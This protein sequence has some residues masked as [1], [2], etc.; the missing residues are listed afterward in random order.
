MLKDTN[1]FTGELVHLTAEDPKTLAEAL[2][3]WSRDTEYWRFLAAESAQAFSVKA[4]QTWLEK[5][6]GK[7]APGTLFFAIRSRED[8]RLIGMTD[9]EIVSFTSGDAFVG[10]GL[11]ER[12]YWGKGYGTDAMQ[13][14]L[15]YAFT[16]LNLHRVTL[17]VFEYNPRAVRSYEKA[18]F[19]RE[20]CIRQAL[21]RDGRRWDIYFMGILKAEWMDRQS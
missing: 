18:G 9:L 20:G 2:S 5:E 4:T 19:T 1:L 7:D 6:L 10:I 16:E 12:E 14:I 8:E 15:R 17:T 11:G 13:V 3:T 21:N